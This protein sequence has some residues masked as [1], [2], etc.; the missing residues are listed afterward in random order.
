MNERMKT[1]KNKQEKVRVEKDSLGA[2]EIPA[3]AWWGPQTERSR[4]NFT[5]GGKMP[6]VVIKAILQIKKKQQLKRMPSWKYW[7][8]IKQ[9][10][11]LLL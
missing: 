10:L 8:M 5:A 4:R 7:Q 6:L 2:I 3:G 9:M 11:L 1:M